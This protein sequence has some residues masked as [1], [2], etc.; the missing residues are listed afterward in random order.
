VNLRIVFAHG[1][2]AAPAPGAPAGTEARA[3]VRIAVVDADRDLEAWRAIPRAR[4][5]ADVRSPWC[6]VDLPQDVDVLLMS[7]G[8]ESAHGDLHVEALVPAELQAE[9]EQRAPRTWQRLLS[10]TRL[11]QRDGVW[12][13]ARSGAAARLLWRPAGEMA[14]LERESPLIG[15]ADHLARGHLP[16]LADPGPVALALVRSVLEAHWLARRLGPELAFNSATGAFTLRLAPGPSL[17]E[18]ADPEATDLRFELHLGD[19]TR[20]PLDASAGAGVPVPVARRALAWL[21]GGP[22]TD[23]GLFLDPSGAAPAEPTREREHTLG[24]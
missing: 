17:V 9:L 18:L 20:V 6:D 23:T 11:L 19:N 1:H 5:L 10:R 16:G 2:L 15:L 12:H 14:A 24:P 22:P 8:Q 4:R 13:V 21:L 7:R 3:R